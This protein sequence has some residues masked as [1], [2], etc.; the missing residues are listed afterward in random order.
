M[1][2]PEHAPTL[3][4]H[5]QTDG[6]LENIMPLGG[7]IYRVSGN[8]LPVPKSNRETAKCVYSLQGMP[9]SCL[10]LL[11]RECVCESVRVVSCRSVCVCARACVRVCVSINQS[12]NQREICRRRYTTRRGA[13]TVFSGKHDLESFSECTGVSNVVEVG[14]KSVPGGW[15]TVGECVRACVRACVSYTRNAE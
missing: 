7:A 8:K 3:Y 1:P 12:I 13:P 14:R 11:E 10:D 5:T 6:Q 2:L 9:S 4:T 15:A